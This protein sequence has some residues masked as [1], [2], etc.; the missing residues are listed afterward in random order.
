MREESDASNR[1]GCLEG[2][3]VRAEKW[4]LP[5]SWQNVLERSLKG[6]L[7][8]TL[9]VEQVHVKGIGSLRLTSQP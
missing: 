2:L 9:E 3:A 1:G 8:R 5:L 7:R 4:P 6:D